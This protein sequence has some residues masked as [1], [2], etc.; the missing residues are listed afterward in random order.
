LSNSFRSKSRYAADQ[1]AGAS[2]AFDSEGKLV[3]EKIRRLLSEFMTGFASSAGTK[4]NG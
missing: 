3:D 4:R 1:I 2:D